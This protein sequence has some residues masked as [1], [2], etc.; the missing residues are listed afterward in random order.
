VRTDSRFDR[1]ALL[2]DLDPPMF[3]SEASYLQRLGL[4]LP[5]ERKRLR[6]A[7]FSPVVIR[8]IGTDWIGLFWS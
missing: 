1:G 2:S 6:R 3:E 7:D 4:L 8:R 5:G